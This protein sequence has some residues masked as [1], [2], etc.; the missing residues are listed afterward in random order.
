M[1]RK[2]TGDISGEGPHTLKMIHQY[3]LFNTR[4]YPL[5]QLIHAVVQNPRNVRPQ[6]ETYFEQMHRR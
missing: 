2:K 5:F 6:F 1:A 4:N 3:Q